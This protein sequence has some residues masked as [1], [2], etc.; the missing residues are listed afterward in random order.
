MSGDYEQQMSSGVHVYQ[1]HTGLL[2]LDFSH[3]VLQMTV[4]Q[5]GCANSRFGVHYCS[6]NICTNKNPCMLLPGSCIFIL[7]W[8]VSAAK[9]HDTEVFALCR[10]GIISV[11]LSF[12][13]CCA[14]Y[15][16]VT[17]I[18]SS[19]KCEA[20]VLS[21][22]SRK[23]WPVLF[24]SPQFTCPSLSCSH[25]RL[26]VILVVWMRLWIQTA[27]MVGFFLQGGFF[28]LFV[29]RWGGCKRPQG[30]PRTRWGDDISQLAQDMTHVVA[31]NSWTWHQMSYF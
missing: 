8:T 27:K 11:T 28:S 1:H 30:W 25:E 20:I 9:I 3:I 5:W 21:E 26:L 7:S 14:F 12:W 29:L 2:T 6:Q 15:R 23:R 16:V 4:C 24:S 31:E 10:R 22:K 17:M 13:L 18:T 19:S